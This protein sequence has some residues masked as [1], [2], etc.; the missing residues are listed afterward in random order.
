[1]FGEYMVTTIHLR[2]MYHVTR[3]RAVSGTLVHGTA[4]TIQ[5]AI[6]DFDRP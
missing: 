4:S 2:D 3:L 6:Q 1:M 5:L